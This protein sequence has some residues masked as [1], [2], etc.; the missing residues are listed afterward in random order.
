MTKK[1][2]DSSI[3]ILITLSLILNYFSLL[4]IQV[5][6]VKFHPVSFDKIPLAI[7][8]SSNGYHKIGADFSIDFGDET[9]IKK[10]SGAKYVKNM[11]L[12]KD[13]KGL[14][15]ELKCS[16]NDE[17]GTSLAPEE[18]KI[19]LVDSEIGDEQIV[20]NSIPTLR[21]G[22]NDCGSQSIED[23]ARFDFSIPQDIFPQNY[24][25]V[26]DITF[27]EAEWIFIN[28]VHILR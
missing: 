7:I 14:S 2:A 21:L 25:I 26:I 12:D 27:D 19:Y 24:K 8:N 3:F 18:T 1:Y 4:S 6:G 28:P 9:V 22:D 13:D 17:C 5:N 16:S 15:L 10:D 20:K 23:C 11:Q